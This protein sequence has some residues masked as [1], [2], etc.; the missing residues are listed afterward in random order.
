MNPAEQILEALD[1]HL[2]GPARIRIL[3]GAALILGYGLNRS[4]EGVDLL[5][6][7]R[8]IELLISQ[9][10]FAVALEATNR[11]LEQGLYL[12][13]I[14]GPEQQILTPEPVAG[15]PWLDVSPSQFPVAPELS[16]WDAEP[17][18]CAG[19]SS[20]CPLRPPRVSACSPSLSSIMTLA[21]SAQRRTS[22][23]APSCSDWER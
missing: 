3:G 12:S 17:P 6:D 15:L 22:A 13:H 5:A 21:I 23:A 18:G 8:E 4:T 7:D 1:R 2:E 11:E 10:N 9:A 19:V 14:W 16:D 20:R